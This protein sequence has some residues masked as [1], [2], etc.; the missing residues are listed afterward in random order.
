[1]RLLAPLAGLALAL[2]S[3][4]AAELAVVCSAAGARVILVPGGTSPGE[5]PPPC[6]RRACHATGGRRSPLSP[7]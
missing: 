2:P 6:D 1:M 4:A 5:P 7:R 3:P